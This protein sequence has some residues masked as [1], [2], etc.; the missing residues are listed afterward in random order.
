MKAITNK[1]LRM[2]HCSEFSDLGILAVLHD[3][4]KRQA[5]TG[6]ES[7]INHN[8]ADHRRDN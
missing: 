7:D 4:D 1:I 5:L 6:A 8:S 3:C 2:S